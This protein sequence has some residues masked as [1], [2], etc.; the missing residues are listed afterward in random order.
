MEIA[1]VKMDNAQSENNEIPPI[2]DIHP[3]Q[4]A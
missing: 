3:K 4:I 1:K 2:P